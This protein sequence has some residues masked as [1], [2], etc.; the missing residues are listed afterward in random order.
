MPPF[1]LT[2]PTPL[3]KVAKSAFVEVHVNDALWPLTIVLGFAEKEL[4]VGIDGAAAKP[5]QPVRDNA[6]R[7][8]TTHRSASLPRGIGFLIIRLEAVA[9]RIPT[10]F[11]RSEMVPW[12]NNETRIA[13]IRP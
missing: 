10:Q 9:S 12:A 8:K 4:T 11:L 13:Q 3:S 1:G 2:C 6:I 5:T 7:L